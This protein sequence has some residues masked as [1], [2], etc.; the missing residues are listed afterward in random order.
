MT[1]VMDVFTSPDGYAEHAGVQLAYWERGAG[2]RTVLLI[3]GIVQ[4][5]AFWRPSFIDA[6]AER[7]RVVLF[8]N[9][10]TGSSTK[11]V[12]R[13]TAGLWAGDALAVLDAV[14]VERCAIIGYS[15]GGRV[16]QQLLL[17][18]PERV[19]RAVLLGSAVG[20]RRAAPPTQRALQSFVPD[21]NKDAE[22]LRRDGLVALAG[23]GFA[24]RDPDAV[25]EFVQLGATKRTPGAVIPLQIGVAATDVL[26]AFAQ[27]TT[28]V[29]IV[30]GDADPL[31]PYANGQLLHEARPD[32]GFVTLPGCGHLVSWEAES[33]L[34]AAVVP[35]LSA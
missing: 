23:P 8:D 1:P 17:D 29:L 30:H 32:A 13:I 10:G 16:T 31:V 27:T 4:R 22:T 6:L 14:G 21:P 28:P 12:D 34:L 19:E 11:P 3:M 20:G 18:R 5:A 35:F 9:R 25:A 33:E 2:P 7:F 24:E 26:G 15:M